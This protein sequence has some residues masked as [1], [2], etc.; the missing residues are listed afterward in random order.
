MAISQSE[1]IEVDKYGR[2]VYHPDFH[3]KHK[4]KFTEEEL[5]Y[6]CKYNEVDSARHL[7]FA[8]GKTEHTIRGKL[9]ELRK[10]GLY[11]YYKNLNKHW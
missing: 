3:F 4:K 6:I 1:V 9:S 8:I 2:M 7:A 10:K 11:E 5:E